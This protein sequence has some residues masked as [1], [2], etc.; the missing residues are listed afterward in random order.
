LKLKKIKT[1]KI[2]VVIE[3]KEKCTIVPAQCTYT[4]PKVGRYT[5]V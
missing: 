1:Q 5:T 3:E 2:V 4:N